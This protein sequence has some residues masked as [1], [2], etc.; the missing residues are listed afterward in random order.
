[1]L[2]TRLLS[3]AV[4]L[5]IVICCVFLGGVYFNVL[6][7][8]WLSVAGIEFWRLTSSKTF[9]PALGF[10][11]GMVWLFLLDAQLAN[12]DLLEPGLVVLLLM[13]LAWQLLHRKESPVADWALSIAG[14]LYLGVC[15]ACW[16]KLRQF[17][18]DGFW[19][20]VIILAASILADTGA[21]FAGHLWGRRALAPTVSPGKTWEGYIGGVVTGGVLAG[22]LAVILQRTGEAGS[23]TSQYGFIFGFA[24][25]V[26]APLGDLTVSM[27]KREAGEKDS[28][29]IIP[30]HGGALDR[31]D[32]ILW[33]GAIGYCL[34]L[35]FVTV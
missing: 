8:V 14:G 32:S 18:P 34:V 24:V 27:F 4:L 12:V 17:E 1:M 21:Y 11:L 20:V 2:R 31:I 35:C 6:I 16:V 33:A 23:V 13:S 3:V 30:G 10:L 26:L 28:G 5:P 29:R 22:L 7:A 15:G 9:H 19:W 25:A